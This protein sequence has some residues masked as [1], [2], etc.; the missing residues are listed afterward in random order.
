MCDQK[1]PADDSSDSK[2]SIM[3]DQVIREVGNESSYPVLTKTNYSDWA[4]LMKMK[5]KAR[6]LYNI[7]EDGVPL[8]MKK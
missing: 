4:L 5:L 8:S 1:K 2:E 3:I 7:I 6:V